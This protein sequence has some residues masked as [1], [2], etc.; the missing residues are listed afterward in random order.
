MRHHSDV[1]RLES[2]AETLGA[3]VRA[4]ADLALMDPAVPLVRRAQ[5]C[6]FSRV[7]AQAGAGRTPAG[8]LQVRRTG[9]RRVARI[10]I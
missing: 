8:R 1:V 5:D 10:R 4:W 7:V 3:L 6:A 9:N 2:A